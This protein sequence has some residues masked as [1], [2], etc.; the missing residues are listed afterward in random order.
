MKRLWDAL[1]KKE[2]ERIF[3][4]AELLKAETKKHGIEEELSFNDLMRFHRVVLRSLQIKI[5]AMALA[6]GLI[7]FVIERI[8]F[9]KVL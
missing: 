9:Y 2:T 4:K 5:A 1:Y 6:G 7:A 3:K 8:L